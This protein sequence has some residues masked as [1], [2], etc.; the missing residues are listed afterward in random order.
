MGQSRSVAMAAVCMRVMGD[1]A[2]DKTQGC[3]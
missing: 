1:G 2:R 3:I